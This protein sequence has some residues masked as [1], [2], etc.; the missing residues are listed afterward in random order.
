MIKLSFVIFFV[1]IFKRN[2][3][4]YDGFENK[5]LITP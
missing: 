4:I 1:N 2:T 3:E 5:V